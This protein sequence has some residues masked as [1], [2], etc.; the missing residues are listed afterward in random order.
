MHR[1]TFIAGLAALPLAA[2]TAARAASQS[3]TPAPDA[4]PTVQYATPASDA[5]PIAQSGQTTWRGT[6]LNGMRAF[7]GI[8]YAEPPVG[9][10]RFAAPQTIQPTSGPI[11][12]TAFGP[13]AP[14]PSTPMGGASA[15]GE[16]CLVLN[17]FT[18]ADAAADDRLPV[19]VWLHGGAG[20][21]GT[22][23]SYLPTALVNDHRLVVV[24][25]NYRLGALSA[26]SIPGLDNG[27]SF[28]QLDQLVALQWVHTHIAGFGGDPANVTLAGES[29]GALLV[30]AHLCSPLSA[31]LFH[32]A[33]LQSGY[34]LASWPAG[35]NSLDS[36]PVPATY[37]VR[38]RF[39]VAGERALAELKITGS[40]EEQLQAIRALPI[41]DVLA[42]PIPDLWA[43]IPSGTPFLPAS[44]REIIT[45]GR[46]HAVPVL[47]GCNRNEANLATLGLQRFTGQTINATTLD[48]L[49]MTAFPDHAAEVHAQYDPTNFPSPAHVWA[50]IITD[51]GWALANQR[52]TE[53]LAQGGPTFMYQFADR[54]API[55]TGPISLDLGACH[56]AELQYLFD[57]DFLTTSFTPKQQALADTMVA[58]WASFASTGD[59]AVTGASPWPTYDAEQQFV[60]NLDIAPTGI[61]SIDFA[62]DHH[63]AFWE[64]I[65]P[66]RP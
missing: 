33:I 35:T 11:N 60:Q 38:A 16:D 49:I 25:V 42:L 57:V 51:A 54:T 29:F 28:G 3:A 40:P 9:D 5:K 19:V 44:P 15:T 66:W 17:V 10:L 21:F 6:I 53:G 12:A 41:A 65:L 30:A 27:G 36:P 63:L 22:G 62:A 23:N 31:G 18:P 13:A 34:A 37:P 2:S 7:L 59:P 58:S 26:F 61:G 14:Q 32:R 64:S 50:T 46:V 4:T 48:R 39:D 47:T 55:Q 24:T 52:Q 8:R 43:L 45:A 1:R 20:L 56:A